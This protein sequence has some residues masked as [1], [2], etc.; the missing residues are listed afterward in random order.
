MAKIQ[1]KL[2]FWPRCAGSMES[3]L[4]NNGGAPAR[5]D[6]AAPGRLYE[7]E[8]APKPPSRP[9]RGPRQDGSIKARSS[10][11]TGRLG[12]GPAQTGLGKGGAGEA[13]IQALLEFG[14][15]GLKYRG[16]RVVP[17]RLGQNSSFA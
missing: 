16:G 15:R 14:T 5:L 7:K 13:K 8:R 4:A 6:A 3:P 17:T 9:R 10:A 2:E 12:P 1:A 11:Q